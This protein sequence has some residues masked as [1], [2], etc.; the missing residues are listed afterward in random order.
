MRLYV[1]TRSGIL[2]SDVLVVGIAPGVIA[3]RFDNGDYCLVESVYYSDTVALVESM[4]YNHVEA[5]QIFNKAYHTYFEEAEP[6]ESF[7]YM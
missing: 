5:V 6:I 4:R 7:K 3:I 2:P 1:L